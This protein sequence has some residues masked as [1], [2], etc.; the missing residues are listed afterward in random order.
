MIIKLWSMNNRLITIES[1]SSHLSLIQINK[2]KKI[3]WEGSIMV[4][5]SGF[6][7]IGNWWVLIKV[8]ALSAFI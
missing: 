6:L 3:L 7:I 4:S 5:T 8:L 1:I 2:K